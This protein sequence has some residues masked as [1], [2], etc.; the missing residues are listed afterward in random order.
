MPVRIGLLVP[1]SSIYPELSGALVSGV[2][3]ALPPDIVKT[4][5]FEFMPE[6]VK[7]GSR[8]DVEEAAKKLL[9]FNQADILAGLVNY[10]TVQELVPMIEKQ[11]RIGFFTDMGE[12]IP[13]LALQSGHVFFNSYQLWQSEFALGYWA[14]Q[15]FGDK[16]V[17]V[18]SLYDS[19]YHLQS[20]FRQGAIMAGSKEMDYEILHGD[21][22]QS[23]VQQNMK[24][25]LEKM[26]A[27]TP[28][29]IHAIVCG[30]EVIEFLKAFKESGLSDSI[31]LLISTHMAAD[32]MLQQVTD[33]GIECFAAPMYNYYSE[34]K[35]NTDFKNAYIGI[36]GKKPDVF[37]LLGYEMG[38][39]LTA[40]LPELQQRNWEKVQQLLQQ[41]SIRSPR[42]ER[43]FYLDAS[44]P[45]P[46]IDI[47]KIRLKD[48]ALTK[49]V[50]AQGRS[51]SYNHE[52]FHQIQ[53]ENV[54]GW[55]NPYLCI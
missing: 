52:I 43:S 32:E 4:G 15:Q 29:Y 45:Q 3:A 21:V 53:E 35:E 2:Y 55:Q 54:T 20:A 26:Y 33:L 13:S 51:L 31:P 49:L 19:G 9:Y 25:F 12:C 1:Y 17:V 28:A 40:L 24:I 16:G 22:K 30:T 39:M 42:G 27:Q 44:Y 47:E 38:L 8:K 37:A 14:H 46:V 18:M 23:M 6:Y 41:E 36:T 11:R 50:I 34:G 7:Q 10:K 5:F 48:G